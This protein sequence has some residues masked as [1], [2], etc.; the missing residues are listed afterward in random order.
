MR[1]DSFGE[2]QA[3]VTRLIEIFYSSFQL[4]S[5]MQVK[6]LCVGVFWQ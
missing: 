6:S 1:C 2:D 4:I 3:I 5:G